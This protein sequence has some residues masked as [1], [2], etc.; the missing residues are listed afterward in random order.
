M[1]TVPPE[2]S[3]NDK[4][5][6]MSKTPPPAPTKP[7]AA[8]RIDFGTH[9]TLMISVADA[10]KLKTVIDSCAQIGKIETIPDSPKAFYCHVANNYTV[11]QIPALIDWVEAL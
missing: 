5:N 4:I 1:Q 9:Q 3:Q 6:P 8:T 2:I 7:I 10:K 11:E